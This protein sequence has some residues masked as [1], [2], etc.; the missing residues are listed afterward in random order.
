LE[1]VR[2]DREIGELRVVVAR[3]EAEVR[4]RDN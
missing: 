2:R 3:L 1:G 4:E